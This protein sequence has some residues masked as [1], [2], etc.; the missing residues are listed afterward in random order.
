ME[1]DAASK[2]QTELEELLDA[3]EYELT[4][5]RTRGLRDPKGVREAVRRAQQHLG[6]ADALAAAEA[7]PKS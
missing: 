2:Q 7:A 4:R 1:R 3:V 5:A 6:Q